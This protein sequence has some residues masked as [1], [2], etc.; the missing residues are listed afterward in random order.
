M[1]ICKHC[2]KQ[3]KVHKSR[4]SKNNLSKRKICGS[5]S[6]SKKRWKS[7][8]ELIN[9]LGGKCNKCNFKGHPGAFHFHHIN[10]REKKYE[11][12]A[13]KLL[14]KDRWQEIKKCQLLCAN[15]HSIEHSNTTLIKSFGF[16]D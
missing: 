14:K 1:N 16:L 9:F 8:I 4:Q 13:N 11:L 7:K 5:C 15:C 3:F 6:V 2:N 12:N 10:P